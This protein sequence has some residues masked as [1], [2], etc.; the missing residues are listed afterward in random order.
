MERPNEG[1]RDR[2]SLSGQGKA[3]A[4]ASCEPFF[5]TNF[6][7]VLLPKVGAPLP[8]AGVVESIV[9]EFLQVSALTNIARPKAE[10]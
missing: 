5:Y 10:E 6:G 3:R 1:E 7:G 9:M 8:L 2:R 4:K